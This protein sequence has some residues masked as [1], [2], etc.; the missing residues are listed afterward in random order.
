MFLGGRQPSWLTGGTIAPPGEPP[1]GMRRPS[2]TAVQAAPR[3]ATT[4]P[5]FPKGPQDGGGERRHDSSTSSSPHPANMPPP[6]TVPSTTAHSSPAT[7][8]LPS[9]PPSEDSTQD[10]NGFVQPADP[11]AQSLYSVLAQSHQSRKRGAPSA[12]HGSA[13]ALKRT[14]VEESNTPVQVLS[15]PQVQNDP[16][17]V[18][19]IKH[20]INPVG[21]QGRMQ[22]TSPVQGPSRQSH[23]S[24]PPTMSPTRQQRPPPPG[25]SPLTSTHASPVMSGNQ[26]VRNPETNDQVV[27]VRQDGSNSAQISNMPNVAQ[28]MFVGVNAGYSMRPQAYQNGNPQIGSPQF[29]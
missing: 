12:A 10:W 29:Q 1:A 23:S 2:T 16:A 25:Q 17:Y 24:R 9:P 19:T 21:G 13:S 27:R 7:P 5:V 8:V 15:R 6:H 20:T 22:S 14:R 26:Q 28:G 18:S 3:P 4:T 11:H